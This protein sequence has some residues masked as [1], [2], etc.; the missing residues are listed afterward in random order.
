[1]FESTYNFNFTCYGILLDSLNIIVCRK[2]I[3]GSKLYGSHFLILGTAIINFI[4]EYIQGVLK[5]PRRLNI[6]ILDLNLTLTLDG[7]P[8]FY[9]ICF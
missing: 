3:V 6:F 7:D 1:M 8:N 2:N 9:V 5:V 4:P